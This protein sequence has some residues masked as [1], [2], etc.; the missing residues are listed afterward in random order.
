MKYFHS[1]LRDRQ[2]KL[3]DSDLA[4][5][6]LSG[7][8]QDNIESWIRQGFGH[9][10]LN[11]QGPNQPPLDTAYVLSCPQMHVVPEFELRTFIK[12]RRPVCDVL[13]HLHNLIASLPL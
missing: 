7:E 11:L 13:I 10:G 2:A 9:R 12:N 6:K 3:V 8:L 1:F 5:T 4:I